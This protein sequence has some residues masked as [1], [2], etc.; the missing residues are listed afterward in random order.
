LI[1]DLAERMSVDERTALQTERLR[2]LVD[3]LLAVRGGPQG[4]LLRAAGVDAGAGLTLDDLP[5]LPATTKAQLWDA[6]PFGMLAVPLDRCVSVHGSSGTGGRPTIVAYTENDLLIWARVMARGLAGAGATRS[7]IVHNAYGYGLFTGGL[8]VHYGARELGATVVPVSGGNTERQ[9][10]L[11]LDLHPDVL[12]CTPS[13]AFIWAKRRWRPVST[14]PGSASR[15]AS[16][17]PNRGPRS[18]ARRSSC[19]SAT[20]RW[21]STGCPR[22][23]SRGG[24]RDPRLG[25]WLHV[26]EDHF[27]VEAL[28]PQ[29]GQPVAD[30]QLAS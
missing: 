7:S 2:A 11:I 14:R 26:Q 22:S 6:Y 28:D 18:C 10:R 30:G 1:L 23:S 27:Y 20:G 5:R 17:A 12:T 19:C 25:G 4:A 13:Y 8:G 21:T 15:S 3:R 9:L 29:T 16:T 24:L